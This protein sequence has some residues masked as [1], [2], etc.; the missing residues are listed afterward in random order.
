MYLFKTFLLLFVLICLSV[1]YGQKY[2]TPCLCNDNTE[3]CVCVDASTCDPNTFTIDQFGGMAKLDRINHFATLNKKCMDQEKLCCRL[4]KGVRPVL[5][6][7]LKCGHHTQLNDDPIT[8]ELEDHDHDRKKFPWLVAITLKE[9]NKNHFVSWGSI[10]HPRAILTATHN[11]KSKDRKILP[12]GPV[13]DEI[14]IVT[15]MVSSD[16]YEGEF[17]STQQVVKATE[18]IF[19]TKYLP[20]NLSNDAALVILEKPLELNDFVNTICLPP[21]DYRI[22]IDSGIEG[23]KCTL[24]GWDSNNVSPKFVKNESVPMVDRESCEGLL[25]KTEVGEGLELHS[26]FI[27]AGG[28]EGAGACN[29]TG[30][31]PLFCNYGGADSQ[32]VQVGISSWGISC[33]RKDEPTVYVNVAMFVDWIMDKLESRNLGPY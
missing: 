10:V 6:P 3:N 12:E 20:F 17:E 14:E 4:P 21:R 8:N 25:R 22:G 13:K 26:S 33:Y 16:D 30:G 9:K 19:H 7:K 29:G 27:C 23:T 11:L 15:G 28:E 32:A 31:A 18:L 24:V 5:P 2:D 1:C